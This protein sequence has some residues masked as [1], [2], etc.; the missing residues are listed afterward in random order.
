MPPVT[1]TAPP[2]P[3]F[4]WDAQKAARIVLFTFTEPL[5]AH[6][7]T[8]TQVVVHFFPDGWTET[9]F[10][11]RGRREI[12]ARQQMSREA[13]HWLLYEI[14]TLAKNPP[15]T[16]PASQ[17]TWCLTLGKAGEAGFLKLAGNYSNSNPDM[18][19]I[20]AH[21]K[22]IFPKMPRW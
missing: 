4:D 2:V 8:E 11:P 15:P 5:P 19:A 17:Q 18:A 14:A 1:A 3:G 9:R 16:V 20:Y 13:W 6:G 7:A 12:V 21:I 10:I 22:T